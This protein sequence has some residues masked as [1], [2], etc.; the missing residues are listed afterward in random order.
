MERELWKDC[1][2]SLID[3]IGMRTII[4]KGD[5]EGSLAMRRFWEI[6]EADVTHHMSAHQHAYCANDSVWL[7]A[8]VSEGAE[9]YAAALREVATLKEAIDTFHR[10]YA[11]CVK[12]QPFP[13]PLPIPNTSRTRGNQPEFVY[14]RISSY[15]WANCHEIEKIFQKYENKSRRADWYIDERIAQKIPALP[16]PHGQHKIT[17]LPE[18]N[19][20]EIYLFGNEARILAALGQNGQEN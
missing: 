12:G 11:I 8:D 7:L 1:I 18:G 3:V 6:V 16:K 9:A 10:S 19:E 2:V 4:A 20:R 17:M 13:P 15:A 14:L 5:S